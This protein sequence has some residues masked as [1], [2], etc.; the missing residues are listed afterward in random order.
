MI[1][2]EDQLL[3]ATGYRRTADLERCL[4]Q[5]NIRYFRGRQGR[6]W[7]TTDLIARAVDA[8]NSQG[9]TVEFIDGPAA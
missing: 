9:H 1:I 8:T 3:E 7:T 2:T 5:Q 4:Y 6:I